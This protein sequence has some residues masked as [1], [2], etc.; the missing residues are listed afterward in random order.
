MA[1]Q[2]KNIIIGVFVLAALVIV[3]FIL[4]FLHPSVGDEGQTMYVRFSD[5]DK[6]NVGTP[7]TL[8]G[9]PI[10]DVAEIRTLHPGRDGPT[11][12]YGHYYVYELKLYIDS[13]QKIYDTDSISLRT[14]GLLGERSISIMPQRPP[15][16][17][18]PHQITKEDI[19]YASE[20]GSVEEAI[21]DF[22]QVADK[23]DV[24]LDEVSGILED[25]R[26]EEVAKHVGAVV[27]NLSDIT[28]ALNKPE[29]W[30][31][32]IKNFEHFSSDLAKRFPDT[33]EKIDRT[34]SN[35]STLTEGCNTFVTNINTGK[36]SLGKFLLKDDIYLNLK[37]VLNKFETI[38]DDINH[39]GLFFQ[40][41]KGWQRLRAR[42]LNLLQKLCT[43]QEFRNYFNDEID[44]ITTSLSRVSMVL[45]RSG[46]CWPYGTCYSLIEDPNFTKVFSELLRRVTNMEEELQMYNQQ[47][48]ECQVLDTELE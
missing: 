4:L 35:A 30:S 46:E 21:K 6:V 3:V 31:N 9:R 34:F 43:P 45:E 38:A 12:A 14:A 11:D 15:Q 23:L 48:I 22:K 16:G 32:M 47:L 5:I 24:V 19:L 26:K 28:A 13:H 18:T 1:D 33:W 40:T 25:I 7:V 36:G 41:D 10:G 39:Y 27:Q 20:S 37:S 8:A 44:Q 2:L 17:V 29:E 42:R